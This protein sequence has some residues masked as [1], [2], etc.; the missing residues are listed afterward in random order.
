MEQ[1][2]QYL[3]SGQE[4]MM[5]EMKPNQGRVVAIRNEGFSRNTRGKE[6]K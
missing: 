4:Q 3:L 6:K 1:I 5:A 2:L